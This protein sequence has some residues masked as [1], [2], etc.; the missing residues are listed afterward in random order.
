MDSDSAAAAFHKPSNDPSN[1]KYRRR[2]PASA[3][4]SD[5]ERSVHERSSTPTREKDERRDHHRNRYSSS[6]RDGGSNRRSYNDRRRDDYKKREKYAEEDHKNSYYKLSPH[7][8]GGSDHSR[9]ESGSRDGSGHRSKYKKDDEKRSSWRDSKELDD[10][11]YTR[12]EKGKSY[13]QETRGVKD[14]Y[15]KEP[16]QLLD[17]QSVATA[18]KSNFSV[19]KDTNDAS[20]H[21]HHEVQS[22]SSKQGQELAAQVAAMK[23][24]ELV[25]RNLIGTGVVMSTDQKKKLLWGS[26]K[27]TPTQEV[28][29]RWDTSMFSDRE[30]QEKFNKLMVTSCPLILFRGCESGAETRDPRQQSCREAERASDGF[31]EAVHCWASS[32]GWPN[33]WFRALSVGIC[34]TYSLLQIRN[35][36]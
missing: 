30:R 20:K 22:S 29:H 18:N 31:G 28:A 6:S 13:D 35:G 26:K 14:R 2:S 36:V 8:R 24:A 12:F 5:G 7:T 9:R 1:R 3:S 21:V 16:R 23:A 4:S 34:C 17:D 15:F 33:C 10:M 25:N 19:G 11:K 27:T 32:K